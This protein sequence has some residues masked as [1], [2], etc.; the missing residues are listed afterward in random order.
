VLTASAEAV[1]VG[2]ERGPV[3]IRFTRLPSGTAAAVGDFV[4]RARS[5]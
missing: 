4:D 2:G 5:R 1:F 3:G